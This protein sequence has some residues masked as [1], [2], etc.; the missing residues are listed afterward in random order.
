MSTIMQQQYFSLRNQNQDFDIRLAKLW[1]E[2]KDIYAQLSTHELRR[3]ELQNRLYDSNQSLTGPAVS[4]I[5]SGPNNGSLRRIVVLMILERSKVEMNLEKEVSIVCNFIRKYKIVLKD[6][7]ILCREADII[8]QQLTHIKNE[9]GFDT[10][11]IWNDI[12]TAN[13]N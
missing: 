4:E 13:S 6:H 11:I 5:A 1:A 3:N 8:D 9:I 2:A 12:Y 7:E 10:M